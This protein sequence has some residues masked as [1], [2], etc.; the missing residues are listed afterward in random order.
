MRDV[1]LRMCGVI[2]LIM[3]L[4][5][6]GTELPGAESF[7]GHHTNYWI[8]VPS[9]GIRTKTFTERTVNGSSNP[10]LVMLVLFNLLFDKQ[11]RLSP[12]F[13]LQCCTACIS[14]SCNLLY[15]YS[16]IPYICSEH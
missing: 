1:F 8:S 16:P 6:T 14:K 4:I 15:D 2:N 10:E 11:M 12:S 5:M 9:P 3:N 7:P 13:F